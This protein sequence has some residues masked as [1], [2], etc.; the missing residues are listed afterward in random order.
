MKV[1]RMLGFYGMHGIT[2]SIQFHSLTAIT[3]SLAAVLGLPAQ[4]RQVSMIRPATQ[5]ST[6]AGQVRHKRQ[7][8][9]RRTN[10]ST[11]RFIVTSDD[12]V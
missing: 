7:C 1:S 8:A 4:I 2:A 5:L 9:P 11:F 10:R 6:V 3:S 12:R